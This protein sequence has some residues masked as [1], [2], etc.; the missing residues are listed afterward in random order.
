MFGIPLVPLV[1]R[2]CCGYL[3]TEGP[4]QGFAAQGGVGPLVS[5]VKLSGGASVIGCHGCQLWCL[6]Y[7]YAAS[8]TPDESNNHH[9]GD[10]LQGLNLVIAS[11]ASEPARETNK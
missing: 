3:V 1:G 5:L 6:Y 7:R 8:Q 2:E 11:Q 4:L 9:R 10:A